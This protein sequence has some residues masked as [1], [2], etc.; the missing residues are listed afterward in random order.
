M[1]DVTYKSN[2][3]KSLT[4]VL[5]ISGCLVPEPKVKVKESNKVKF[6][7]SDRYGIIMSRGFGQYKVAYFDDYGVRYEVFVSPNE[8][9]IVQE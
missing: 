6:I 3:I 4:V 8:V 9:E 1:K 7:L 5:L 2:L